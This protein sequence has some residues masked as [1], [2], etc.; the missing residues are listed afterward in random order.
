MKQLDLIPDEDKVYYAEQVAQLMTV[1]QFC[2]IEH[3]IKKKDGTLIN[4]FYY[5]SKNYD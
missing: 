2:F 5:G 3:R 1:N 4:V